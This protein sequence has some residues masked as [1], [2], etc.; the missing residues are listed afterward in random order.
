MCVAQKIKSFRKTRFPLQR[1]IR[2]WTYPWYPE[3]VCKNDRN[4]RPWPISTTILLLPTHYL[5]SAYQSRCIERFTK[6]NKQTCPSSS[7]YKP[8]ADW[9]KCSRHCLWI[10]TNQL[11][12]ILCLVTDLQTSMKEIRR[13]PAV[14]INLSSADGSHL[15]LEG[16]MSFHLAL[17]RL[18]EFRKS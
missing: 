4:L 15:I 2:A 12:K 16:D 9:R 10:S 5:L 3:I 8:V 6:I 7:K 17:G 18:K 14:A 1:N 13:V 11:L